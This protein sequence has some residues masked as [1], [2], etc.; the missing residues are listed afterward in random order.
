MVNQRKPYNN[1]PFA[2]FVGPAVS[3]GNPYI[4]AGSI[5]ATLG[6]D[7]FSPLFR[8]Y[9]T[10]VASE[11]AV[12]PMNPNFS[13]QNF[14]RNLQKA[15]NVKDSGKGLLFKGSL[16][17]PAGFGAA[18]LGKK[19][20]NKKA[21]KIRQKAFDEAEGYADRFNRVNQNK[22]IMRDAFDR[23]SMMQSGSI[24]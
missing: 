15:R 7:V 16:L 14:G 3:T 10:D 12:D 21:E 20:I 1:N 8:K 23:F 4:A 2:G 11:G 24:Y 17:G 13:L 19:K 5:G 22:Q 18:L 9:N 6:Y